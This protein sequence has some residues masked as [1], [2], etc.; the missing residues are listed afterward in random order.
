MAIVPHLWF[1]GTAEQ[2]AAFYCSVFADGRVLST[3]RYPE[4]SPGEPGT[5]MTVEWEVQGQRFVGINGGPQH[6]FTEAVSFLVECEDQ[7][8]VDRYWAALT[9][10]GGEEG[11]CG[12][13]KDRFGLSWQVVPR[14]FGEIVSGPHAQDAVAAMMRMTKLDVAVLRA[15]AAGEP[16]P[17]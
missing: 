8:D 1:D 12:W 3:A 4:G 17:A 14:A 5:V 11:R 7:D 13:C 2:A 9:S 6:R 10:D 15:A 16:A